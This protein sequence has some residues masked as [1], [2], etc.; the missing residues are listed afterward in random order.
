MT[1]SVKTKLLFMFLEGYFF[2]CG[3]CSSEGF[4][5][6]CWYAVPNLDISHKTSSSELKS[7]LLH[8]ASVTLQWDGRYH[9]NSKGANATASENEPK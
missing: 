1:Y 3:D 4:P 5:Q 7:A 6:N 8:L 9:N 2:F